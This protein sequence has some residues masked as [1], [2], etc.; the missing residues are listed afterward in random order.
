MV[1][2][3][4][5]FPTAEQNRLEPD[6]IQKVLQL[7]PGGRVLDV[8]CGG[9]RHA[10]ELAMRGF[11]V[12]GVDLTP[13]FLAHARAQAVPIQGAVM[14][15]QREMR[16]LPWQEEF[17]GAYCFGNSFGYLD[18][19]G[20]AAFVAA[21][22]RALK[23]GGRFLVDTGTAAEVFFPNYQER[24]WYDVGGTLFLIHNHPD[25][26]SSRLET[27]LTCVRDG[28]VEKHWFSQ[29]IYTY[30]ELCRLLAGTGLGGC[31]GYGSVNAEPFR[32]G[33][34]HLLLVATKKA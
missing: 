13:R 8:P 4:L 3:W 25:H 34:H 23:P 15:E 7:P 19:A 2:I 29:R 28:R 18:D 31:A 30:R 10:L 22:A 6:F 9:G 24:S 12:T 27:E 32:L 5:A 14:W 26:V 1:D 17:D 33:S 21:V 16:D 11:R 20:D